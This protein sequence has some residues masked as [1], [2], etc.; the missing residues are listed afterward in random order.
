MEREREGKMATATTTATAKQTYQGKIQN[1]VEN[2]R[3]KQTKST[4]TKAID[5]KSDVKDVCLLP[6]SCS[7][8]FY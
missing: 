4:F 8:C 1:V 6:V 5:T 3:Q 7:V 2:E